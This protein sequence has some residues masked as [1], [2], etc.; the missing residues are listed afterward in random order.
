[1]FDAAF[2]QME[3]ELRFYAAI[4][5]LLIPVFGWVGVGK[6]LYREEK[7]QNLL[8]LS[9]TYSYFMVNL[10]RFLRS[11]YSAPVATNKRIKGWR[12]L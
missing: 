1:M 11:E 3:P 8:R 5:A 10:N 12:Y 4:P 2:G 7:V 9:L 6:V